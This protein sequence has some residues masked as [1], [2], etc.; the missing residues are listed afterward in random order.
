MLEI[1]GIYLLV[2]SAIVISLVLMR[3]PKF[4]D[5]IRNLFQVMY[6]NSRD[7]VLGLFLVID[8]ILLLVILILKIKDYLG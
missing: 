8:A 5:L 4:A 6:L 3:S 2:T 7:I 1:L